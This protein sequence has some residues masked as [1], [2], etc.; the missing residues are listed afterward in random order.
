[1]ARKGGRCGIHALCASD[2]CLKLAQ[3]R[4]EHPD[5]CKEHGGSFRCSAAG[6]KASA[7]RPLFGWG[8][9]K[10]CQTHGGGDR[11]ITAGCGSG[12]AAP[13][14]GW[15]ASTTPADMRC[16][17]HARSEALDALVRQEPKRARENVASLEKLAA[18][19]PVLQAVRFRLQFDENEAECVWTLEQLE[20]HLRSNVRAALEEAS[21]DSSN[22]FKCTKELLRPVES[23]H[24]E[25]L[26]VQAH[27]ALSSG[28]ISL[29]SLP[30]VPPAGPDGAE[31][32]RGRR[33]QRLGAARLLRPNRRG[34]PV[35]AA[36]AAL[37]AECATHR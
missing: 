26:R 24:V 37:P 18:D 17:T 13:F 6:C 10:L 9:R 12:A 22:R 36:E 25:V 4:G 21:A 8:E 23:F 29:H 20:D 32:D 2:G 11:C 34:L 14:G 35:A 27:L 5:R 16:A 1:V 31:L 30:E 33:G 19:D 15:P 7:K 3:R 28:A